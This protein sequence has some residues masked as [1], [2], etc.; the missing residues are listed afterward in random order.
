MDLTLQS[1]E[2][3]DI[4]RPP[5][6]L[7]ELTSSTPKDQ[8][9]SRKTVSDLLDSFSPKS[10]SKKEFQI[11]TSSPNFPITM[12][13]QRRR[14][15]Q[16]EPVHYEITTSGDSEGADSATSTFSS[17]TKRRT[18]GASIIDLEEDFLEVESPKAV[19]PRISSAGHS[20][21]QHSDLHL[22]LR[23]QENGDKLVA[24]RRRVAN[25]GRKKSATAHET[26]T[27]PS[28]KTARN[29]IREN[30]SK[31]TAVRRANFYVAKRE[32]F[33]PLLPESNNINR[34]IEARRAAGQ[35]GDEDITI[36]Y[37]ALEKQPE[38]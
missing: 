20:L 35:Q 34:L 31:E 13:N 8:S 7:N 23:A 15:R 37:E 12:S 1:N 25:G 9:S 16:K 2:S 11:S 24:R 21:R 6:P 3:K 4:L 29:E 19:R 10:Q 27:Q 32:Y 36:P 26:G 30:I 17:P 38:G 33:L 5:N 18:S 28:Q 14:L 22:S